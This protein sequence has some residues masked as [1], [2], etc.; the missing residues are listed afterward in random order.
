MVKIQRM[1]GSRVSHTLFCRVELLTRAA[2][3][4]DKIRER[5]KKYRIRGR[6]GGVAVGQ[7]RA[8][9]WKMRGEK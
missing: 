7:G 8:S 3:E 2:V 6:G 9:E 4:L 5:Y 1:N